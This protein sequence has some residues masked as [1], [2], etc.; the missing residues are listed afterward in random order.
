MR[1]LR[2]VAIVGAGWAG[3]A[4]AVRAAQ[5]GLAVSVFEASRSGGGRARAVPLPLPDG[6]EV[7]ADNGQHILIGAYSETLRLMRLVGA[8]PQRLLLR[9]PLLLQRV[10]YPA[11]KNRQWS[12]RSIALPALLRLRLWKWGRL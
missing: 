9:L 5:G 8:E 10:I 3:L 6:R 4:A 1:P 2:R 11:H 12:A 7:M